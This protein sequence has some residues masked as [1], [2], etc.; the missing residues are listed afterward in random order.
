[1]G[2]LMLSNNSED[3]PERRLVG[4]EAR[5]LAYP[6]GRA[7]R[8]VFGCRGALVQGC[9]G[10]GALGPWERGTGILGEGCAGAG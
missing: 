9:A 10:A 4:G 6:P 3:A 1:M 2:V 8:G 7:L 5:S